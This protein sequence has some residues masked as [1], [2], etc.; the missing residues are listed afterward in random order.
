M[1]GRDGQGVWDGQVHTAVFKMDHHVAAW[2]GEGFG[3]EWIHVCV[4]LSPFAVNL[5]LSHL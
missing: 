5:Q 4:W 2:M 1:E 3:E